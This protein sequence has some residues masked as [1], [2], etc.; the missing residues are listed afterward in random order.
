[1]DGRGLTES[2]ADAWFA[3]QGR[4]FSLGPHWAGAAMVLRVV[5]ALLLSQEVE[6]GVLS[7]GAC[8]PGGALTRWLRLQAMHAAH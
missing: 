5:R 6:V 1:V 8:T 7:G 3:S 4:A 2:I